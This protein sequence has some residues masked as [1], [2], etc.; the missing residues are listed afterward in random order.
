MNFD[1]FFSVLV[2]NMKDG[3]YK[4]NVNK[5]LTTIEMSDEPSYRIAYACQ[6]ENLVIN[7]TKYE[8]QRHEKFKHKTMSLELVRANFGRF[9]IS[10]CNREGRTDFSVNCQSYSSLDILKEA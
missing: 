8:S 10:I 2:E 1:K 6:D 4:E 7:C 9:S 3:Y 5:K